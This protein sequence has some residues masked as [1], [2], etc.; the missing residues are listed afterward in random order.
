MH[1]NVLNTE[2][3]GGKAARRDTEDSASGMGLTTADTGNTAVISKIL[4]QRK[5]EKGSTEGHRGFR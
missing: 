1:S 2:E 5:N 3:N 4:T